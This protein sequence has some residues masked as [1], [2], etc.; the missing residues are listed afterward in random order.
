MDS[1]D[2]IPIWTQILNTQFSEVLFCFPYVSREKKAELTVPA[3]CSQYC[4]PARRNDAVRKYLMQNTWSALWWPRLKYKERKQSI[5]QSLIKR[6]VW[7][8]REWGLRSIFSLAHK[9]AGSSALAAHLPAF[10]PW[11]PLAVLRL[12]AHEVCGSGSCIWSSP[13]PWHYFAKALGGISSTLNYPFNGLC[14]K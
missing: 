14:P 9:V 7:R 5:V 8:W 4:K 2:I 10:G 12:P 13:H 3:M 6:T 1:H 11:T